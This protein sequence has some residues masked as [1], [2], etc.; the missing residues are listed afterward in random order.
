MK[1][2]QVKAAAGTRYILID[3][4]YKVIDEVKRYLKFL[5]SCGKSPN[6]LRSYAYDLLLYYRY[7]SEKGFDVMNL[8]ND[9][10][11]KPI[12]TLSGFLM[13]LQYPR[14]SN[15]EFHF[16]AEDAARKN[17][18]LNRILGTV[19]SFYEYLSANNELPE[20]DIY[21]RQRQ[22]GQFKSFLS[23]M[24][25][26]KKE[27]K[28]S[29]L[30]LPVPD[31]KVQAVTYEEYKQFFN[32]CITRRDKI[33][34]ALLFECG[35]RLSE[36]LG[37][38]LCD[39]SKI[40]QGILDIVPRENNEN[41]ARVKNYAKGSVVLPAYLIDLIIDYMTEDIADADSDF[42]LLTRKGKRRGRP[43]TAY[44]AEQLFLRLSKKT[45]MKVHPHMLRH[46]FAQE[47]LDNGWTLEEVQ[48]CLRHRRVT[49]TAIYAQYT[50]KKKR[51]M[52]RG[53][54]DTKKDELKMVG[55]LLV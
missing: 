48:A 1:V 41:G 26:H 25:L 4:D 29:I 46:G 31:R 32:A 23:E 49:S 45:G 20:L 40:D 5:D 17:R 39:L 55:C 43:M 14:T 47:R 9:P 51:E 42:L 11:R 12:D 54:L 37:I 27:K 33:L 19:L 28:T 24:Y 6:T 15:L 13:W 16:E 22:S 34:V 50:D 35:L 21:R 36:A 38:H 8:C 3:D 52:M 18:S 53:F 7:A 2:Q 10:E 44:S 30:K